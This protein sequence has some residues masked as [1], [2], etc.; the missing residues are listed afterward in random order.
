MGAIKHQAYQ[1][2]NGIVCIALFKQKQQMSRD[3]RLPTMWYV[4]PTKVFDQSAHTRRL[5]RAF[6]SRLNIP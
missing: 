5:I 3:M 6:A 1:I 2:I 4:R